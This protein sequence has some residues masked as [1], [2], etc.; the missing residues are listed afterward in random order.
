MARARNPFGDGR[1]S[2]RILKAVEEFLQVYSEPDRASY[3]TPSRV[4]MRTRYWRR[5]NSSKAGLPVT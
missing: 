2:D 5:T 1:A 3:Q 4:A